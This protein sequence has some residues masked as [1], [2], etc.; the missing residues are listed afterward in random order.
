MATLVNP[1]LL[2]A[3][4]VAAAAA[5][6]AAAALSPLAMIEDAVWCGVVW[7]WTD[8]NVCVESQVVV[9]G[10]GGRMSVEARGEVGAEQCSAVQTETDSILYSAVQQEKNDGYKG[11]GKSGRKKKERGRKR[12]DEG[13]GKA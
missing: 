9:N 2:A 6:A 8:N 1:S 7:F 13:G 5:A 4:V 10:N 11:S 12:E 3:A